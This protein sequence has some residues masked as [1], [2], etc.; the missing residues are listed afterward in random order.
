MG[1]INIIKLTHCPLNTKQLL[2]INLTD[3]GESKFSVGNVENQTQGR[4]VQS[5][6]A[7]H[8][9]MIVAWNANGGVWTQDLWCWKR[10]SAICSTISAFLIS[11]IPEQ[12]CFLFI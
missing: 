9:A 2:S 3:I 12:L 8:C 7:I 1:P 6:N 5:V 10:R 4:W 11:L